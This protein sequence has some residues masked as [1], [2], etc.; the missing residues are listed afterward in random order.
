M[1]YTYPFTGLTCGWNKGVVNFRRGR[2]S[3]KLVEI[4]NSKLLHQSIYLNTY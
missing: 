3:G 2:L 1:F 4:K